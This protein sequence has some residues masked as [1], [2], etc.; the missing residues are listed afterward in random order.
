MARMA[1]L[2]DALKL[3]GAARDLAVERRRYNWDVTPPAT[4]YLQAEHAD[5]RLSQNDESRIDATIELR[6]RFAWQLAA[7]QD[8][9]GVYIIARRKAVLGS[10][11][12]LRIH[13]HLPPGLTISLK[14]HNCQ[15]R[16]D[17]LHGELDFPPDLYESR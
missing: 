9:A 13:A 3:A 17:D 12:R 1:N 8:E 16:L 4:F 15:L 11:A 5:I 10:L 2:R 6:G 14:L 7:E